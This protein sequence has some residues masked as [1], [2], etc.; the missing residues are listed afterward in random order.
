[1]MERQSPSQKSRGM[2]GGI[3]EGMRHQGFE[4]VGWSELSRVCIVGMQ[5][6]R[7]RFE[8]ELAMRFAEG[9]RRFLILDSGGRFGQ[10]ISH[11]PCLRV[12]RVGK[13]FSI[14]PF[15]RCEGL[16]PLAQA[17]FIS[18]SLQL[19]L[20]LGRDER[21]YFERALVSAYE[22]K[23]DDPTFRDISDMLLQIEADSHPR[24]G[25]KIE[26]L[27]NALWEAESGAIGKMAI[28]RQPREVT[29]PAVID[30]SSLEGI[31]ARALVL[32]AL[33]LRA[34]TLR[35]ASLLIELQELFGSF[36][37]ALWWPFMGE[38]LRRFRDLEATE[39]SFQ[40]GAESLSSIPT[41]LLDGSAAVVFCCPLWADE[42]TFIEK[43]LLAGRGCAKPLAKLGMGTAIAWI[44]GS[45]KAILLRYR[46]TPFDAVDEGGVL[47]HMAAL[48]EP[49]EELR[50]PEKREGLLEKLFR[51]RGARHYA[52]E[53]LGLI[54]GGRVPVDAVVGQ[55]DVKLKRAVKL[56]KRNFLIIECMDNSGAYF[57]RLTKAGE[58]ALMEAESPSDDSERSLG[59]ADGGDER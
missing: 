5:R 41:P 37:G 25:Q 47:K 30:V 17:S 3:L 40:I 48:G 39:T 58:R 18:I 11:I 59:R 49:T 24:E 55:R 6:H 31:A 26:S 29:L 51:D 33:L 13:Y 8:M 16:T 28:C 4:G 56:M 15:T 27:R 52:V 38:L 1:M 50:L 23:I 42:L 20:G 43:A 12:Y 21:L 19:L 45:G 22:S 14:S 53:L 2:E 9:G 54:R 36:G 7:E 34:C 35:P 32:V 57:F 46:P 44:R 10:L